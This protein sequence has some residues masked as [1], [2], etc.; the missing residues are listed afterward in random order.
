MYESNKNQQMMVPNKLNDLIGKLTLIGVCKIDCK[1]CQ[2]T[3][4]PYENLPKNIKC[5]SNLY[6]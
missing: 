5:R 1:L 6:N 3:W 2:N 4:N